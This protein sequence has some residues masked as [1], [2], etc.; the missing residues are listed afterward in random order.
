MNP[1]SNFLRVGVYQHYKRCKD[2]V[3]KDK[4]IVKMMDGQ[5]NVVAPRTKGKNKPVQKKKD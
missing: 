4:R 3:M 5:S 2:F 1:T